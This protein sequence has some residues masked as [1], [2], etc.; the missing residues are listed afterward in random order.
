MILLPLL[1]QGENANRAV[2]V[3]L[4]LNS[5]LLSPRESKKTLFLMLYTLEHFWKCLEF[6]DQ[7]FMDMIY[8]EKLSLNFPFSS[9]LT[10]GDC[11]Q[12]C[13]AFWC[14]LKVKEILE[15]TEPVQTWDCTHG[16]LCS[17]HIRVTQAQQKIFQW[18]LILPYEP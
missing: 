11:T 14:C 1:K 16:M 6:S 12:A 9:F 4:I 17:A 2:T 3:Y 8:L 13:L 15:N 10:R 18:S 7:H 5:T